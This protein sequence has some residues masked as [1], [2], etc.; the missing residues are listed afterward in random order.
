[1]GAGKAN[2]VDPEAQAPRLG[3][4]GD[5]F[6]FDIAVTSSL[7]CLPDGPECTRSIRKQVPKA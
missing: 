3:D 6:V 2:T 4:L 1:M 7:G 5:R